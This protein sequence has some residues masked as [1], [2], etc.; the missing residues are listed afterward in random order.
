MSTE[1]NDICG[2]KDWVPIP[3]NDSTTSITDLAVAVSNIPF[4]IF[5]FLSN[6]AIIVTVIKTPSL[7]RSSNILLCN[8]ATANCLAGVTVQPIFAVWWINVQYVQNTCSSQQQLSTAFSVSNILMTGLSF[9]N[10]AVISADRCYAVSRPFAYRAKVTKEGKQIVLLFRHILFAYCDRTLCAKSLI[11]PWQPDDSSSALWVYT[12]SSEATRSC[13]TI[14]YLLKKKLTDH[15][16][17][18]IKG[19]WN[20]K[21]QA[22]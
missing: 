8:L 5:A 13:I 21:K 1:D 20:W 9:T 12:S 18:E 19:C 6:L 2:L 3:V 7:Q 4:G 22:C 10:L 17:R 15:L 16:K 14:S 11:E